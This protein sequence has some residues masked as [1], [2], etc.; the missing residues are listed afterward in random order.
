MK[1]L[2]ALMLCGVLAMP[3]AVQAHSARRA[4]WYSLLIPGWGQ[5]YTGRSSSG[6]GFLAAEAGL[7]GSFFGLRHL[8]EI[9]RTHYRTYAA[10]HAGARPEG[11]HRPGS[12]RADV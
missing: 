11:V 7:W 2:I 4:F 3:A 5:Y 1:R 6:T 12:E 9:R 8:G 10:E